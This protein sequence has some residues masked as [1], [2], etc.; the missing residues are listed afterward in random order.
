M[1]KELKREIKE[2]EFAS[3]LEKLIVWGDSH[4]DELRIGIGVT[5]VLLAAFGALAYFQSHRAAEAERAFQDALE[6]FEAPVAAELTEGADRPTGQVFATAEDKHK[7]AAAAFEGVSRRYGS[8]DIGLK[9]KYYAAL[10]RIELGQY[11]E[12]E[13]ALRE[14]LAQGGDGLVP[15]LARLAL[16]GL[17]RKS[18]ETD[19]AVEAYRTVISSPD[20]NL[21]RD[22]ALHC[23]AG[24]LEDVG[25]WGEARA[26]YR[27]LVEQYPASV[28][29]APA[30]ARVEYLETA[31]EPAQG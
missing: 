18:G 23:L 22:Y 4:R 2:D 10:S 9:S 15:D 16:G 31:P 21:P 25:R 3:W 8:S 13:K 12:A 20:T 28:Y 14:V 17:Y 1:R 29:A 30:R 24:T 11:D 26:A 7:T 27:E 19:R 6:S 5:V